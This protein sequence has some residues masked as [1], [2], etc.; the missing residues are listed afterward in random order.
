MQIMKDPFDLAMDELGDG[1]T[2]IDLLSGSFVRAL[3]VT[4]AAVSTLGRPLG[5]ETVSASDPRAAILDELQFDLG[6][7]PCWDAF[8]T[9]RPVSEPALDTSQ[10]WPAFSAA[11]SSQ[12][13]SSI[14]AFP[15]RVGTLRVG[16]VDLYSLSPVLLTSQ[17]THQA[18]A[19]AGVVGRRLLTEAVSAL[20]DD[21]VRQNRH[22]RRV[23]HQATGVV[24]A[25]LGLTPDDAE[26]VIQSHAFGTG[27][28]M[29]DIAHDITTGQLSF[30]RTTEGIEVAT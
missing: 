19:M 5:T 27:R 28:S 6:E 12:K 10:R 2:P 9:S 29:M 1:R 26:L 22:S 23:I 25:Q 16:A 24:L 17:Q 21:A 11:A 7:G 18:S 20:S 30:V 13:V 15:V 3:P 14:F 4:G 8:H